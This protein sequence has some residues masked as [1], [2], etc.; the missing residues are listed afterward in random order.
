MIHAPRWSQQHYDESQD[1]E[2]TQM[3]IDSPRDNEDMVHIH[4]GVLLIR[5]KEWN[6]AT[7]SNT[8][9]PRDYQ[10]KRSKSERKNT[11][12]QHLYM[13]SKIRQKWT[14]LWNRHTDIENKFVVTKGEGSRGGKDSEFGISR[15]KL[16]YIGWIDNR[17]LLYSTENWSQYP[18]INHNEKEYMYNRSTLLHCRN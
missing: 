14:Y 12:W 4:N 17:V 10:T 7:G 18:V 2:T 5:K 16:V 9:G 3:S 13:E 8:D 15:Y 6:N 11:I 1:T